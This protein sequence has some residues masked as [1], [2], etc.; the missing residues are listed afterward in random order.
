MRDRIDVSHLDDELP[1]P[2]MEDEDVALLL[3]TNQDQKAMVGLFGIHVARVVKKHM[4]FL[5][6]L[7]KALKSISNTSTTRKCCRNQK[8]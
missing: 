5:P 8:W 3:P 6:S 2:C 7:E 4:P 1:T